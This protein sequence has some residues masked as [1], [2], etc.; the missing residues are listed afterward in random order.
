MPHHVGWHSDLHEYERVRAAEQSQPAQPKKPAEQPKKPAEKPAPE[1]KEEQA[2]DSLYGSLPLLDDQ[3][4]YSD[5]HIQ[6]D[7]GMVAVGNRCIPAQAIVGD[8]HQTGGHHFR[9]STGDYHLHFN[10]QKEGG[11][12]DYPFADDPDD[13][14]VSESADE[15]QSEES[16]AEE[17][18]PEPE[19]PK[20][21]LEPVQPKQP[22]Q[23]P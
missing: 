5:T 17:S 14:P 22:E 10:Q 19:E 12:D 7:E 13:D 11:D 16:A 6:C 3:Y 2:K 8:D 4:I 18:D 20:P 9:E 15:S 21:K 1:K 23:K